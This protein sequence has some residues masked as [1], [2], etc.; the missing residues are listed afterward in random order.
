MRKTQ[1]ALAP[2]AFTLIELLVVIAIIAILASM[3]L[4]A[5][6]K[7]KKSA[8]KAQCSNNLRQWGYALVMYAGDYRDFFPRQNQSNGG[9]DLAWVNNDFNDVFLAPYVY[10]NRPGNATS[11]RMAGDVIVCP[12]DKYHQ[13]YEKIHG[14]SNLIGY[15][16]LPGRI[17]GGAGIDY[18]TKGYGNWVTNRAKIGSTYKKAPMMMD[19]IQYEMASSGAGT[20]WNAPDNTSLPNSNHPGKNNVPDGGNF[21]FEDGRVS[22]YKFSWRSIALSTDATIGELGRKTWIG[23]CVPNDLVGYGQ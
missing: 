3:L 2:G 22:W 13:W 17:D 20:A 5:L 1:R 11:D 19:R 9:H 6:S 12:T 23:Y 18:G 10:K 16:L 21:L 4:P 8:Q 14:V 7:A 15:N